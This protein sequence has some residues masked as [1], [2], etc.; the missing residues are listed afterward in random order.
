MR[1]LL[2]TVEFKP[3][4]GGM[5]QQAYNMALELKSQGHEV[6]VVTPKVKGYSSFDSRVNLKITR[7][8]STI[9]VREIIASIII[10]KRTSLGKL[11]IV[12]NSMWYP[13]GVVCWLLSHIINVRYAVIAHGVEVL[14]STSTFIKRVKKFLKPVRVS[15]F[16][17]SVCSFAV[18]NY[19]KNVLINEGVRAEKVFFLPNGVFPER[20]ENISKSSARKKLGLNRE[21]IILLTVARLD[22]YKGH[23]YVIKALPLVQKI[24]SNKV[25]YCIVGEGPYINQLKSIVKSLRLEGRV[26][27]VGFVNDEELKYWYA[28]SD[29]FIMASREIRERPDVEGFGIVFLE[30]QLAGI[31]VIGGRSG[32]IADAVINGRTGLLVDPTDPRAIAKGI[33]KIINDRKLR[34]KLVANA[35]ARI[36]KELNWRVIIKKMVR[37]LRQNLKA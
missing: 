20:F 24:I 33:V 12:V 6:E 22:D 16:N 23:D 25:R 36:E 14:D 17:R 3:K 30:A 10:V 37:I 32:G 13:C 19:T 28:S 4:P 1:I 31:P 35:R 2:F 7:I 11:D 5:A 21:D 15:I 18:S 34:Y 26:F 27:F 8:P 29:I 9:L